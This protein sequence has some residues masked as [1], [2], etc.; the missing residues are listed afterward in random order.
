MFSDYDLKSLS[1]LADTAPYEGIR[2]RLW[3]RSIAALLGHDRGAEESSVAAILHRAAA[4]SASI[5]IGSLDGV[6][7]PSPLSGHIEALESDAL[8][9]SRPFEGACRREL[10]SGEQLHLSIA[11]DKGFHHGDVEVLGRWVALDAGGRRYGYRVSIPSVLMHEERRELHRIPVAFDLAP[12]GL[13]LRPG[14]LTEI[15][16]G[17]VVDVSEGG[18]CLRCDLRTIVRPEESV[19]VRADFPAILPSIHTRCAVAHVMDARQPGR[20]DVGL[21]FTEPQPQLGQAIRAL[22][23]RRINRAG[24]A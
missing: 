17:T 16:E 23:L 18:M 24:A 11:A 14:S 7:L 2:M 6:A 10:V 15:G 9:I 13:L 3:F 12:S 8:V 4:R 19:I 22:E 1:S 5:G 21:R 20:C